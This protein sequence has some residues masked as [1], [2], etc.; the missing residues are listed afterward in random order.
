MPEI[1]AR[2]II[3]W[4]MEKYPGEYSMGQTR[5]LQRRIAEWREEQIS[6]VKKLRAL[7]VNKTPPPPNYAITPAGIHAV[8]E[9]DNDCSEISPSQA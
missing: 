2:E 9:S 7:M 8:L 3:Q 4:L 1:V 5:T 6:H